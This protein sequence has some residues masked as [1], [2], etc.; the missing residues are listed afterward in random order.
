MQDD[1]LAHIRNGEPLTFLQKIKL[2]VT[3]SIPSIMAQLTSIIMQYIDAAMVGRLGA[4]A[5]AAIGLVAS[6]TWL[7]GGLCIS[8][9]A[10]FSIQV[11]QLIGAKK[12]D[13]AQLVLRHSYLVILGISLL[14][15]AIGICISGQLPLW[16]GSSGSISKDAAAYFLVF[17]C[18]LPAMALNRLAA[19]MMQCSGNMKVPGVL[20]C[21]MCGWDVLLNAVFIYG[22]KMGVTGAALGT[23]LSEVITAACMFYFLLCRTPMFKTKKRESFRMES[24][25]LQKAAQISIPIALER[26]IMS[27]GLVIT[28]SIVAPLGAVAI[29]ANSLAVTAESLCYMPGFGIADAA[30]TLVG[31]SIG[32]GRKDMTKS[33][34]RMTVIF[35]MLFMAVTAVL[36]FVFAPALMGM[37]TPDV[38]VREMG[39]NILRIE[40]FA[41]PLYG[42]SIV[43]AGVLRGAGD[44]LMS[45]VLSLI[46]LWCIRIPLS[47]LLV[48]PL[49]LIGVWIAMCVELCFRGCIF[50]WRLLKGK[51]FEKAG[52]K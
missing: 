51:W 35:A 31:Q 28:T 36:L 25:Y 45:S 27:G 30:T 14:L 2:V 9:T 18:S 42:A 7:F 13:K 10:G 50:L 44:T 43:V 15:A 37:L 1:L 19:S 5:T 6:T 41:E 8:A 47:V 29:A 46:S 4:N 49:K 26:L 23:A 34:S 20:N 22:F 48:G 12:Y 40:A 3:L 11:A 21:L 16:L 17:A 39:T 32:A 52:L 24:L 33:F 38:Q